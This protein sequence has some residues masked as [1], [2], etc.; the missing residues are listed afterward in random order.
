MHLTNVDVP[1]LRSAY[2][3]PDSRQ[4]IQIS[5]K[6]CVHIRCLLVTSWQFTKYLRKWCQLCEQYCGLVDHWRHQMNS[7]IVVVL[8]NLF[9]LSTS[10][11]SDCKMPWVNDPP[12]RLPWF[13]T[14]RARE[15]WESRRR[16]T[17]SVL[18]CG[19]PWFSRYTWLRRTVS[20]WVGHLRKATDW[21]DCSN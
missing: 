14:C 21:C 15:T 11:L 9:C 20:H 7:Q 2:W 8:N 1:N 16:W 18:S 17:S 4:K 10:F 6:L 5:I 19:T 12:T 13:S 3:I